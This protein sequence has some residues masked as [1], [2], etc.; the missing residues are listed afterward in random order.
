[1]REYLDGV[2]KAEKCAQYVG[3]GIATHTAQELKIN[4]REVF[5]FV[6]ETCLRLTRAKCQLGA[7]EVELSSNIVVSKT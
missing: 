4:M 1:M 5:K 3:I 6:R 2:I 7:K